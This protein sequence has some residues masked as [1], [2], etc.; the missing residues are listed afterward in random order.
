MQKLHP[1]FGRIIV[2]VVLT[3]IMTAI[4]AGLSTII[5]VGI[6]WTALRIWPSA[7]M[8]SWA[9]AAPTALF[10]LPFAQWLTSFVVRKN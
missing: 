4:V 7:W 9:V 5:A 1:R 10:V 8:A 2:P 6:N 3:F